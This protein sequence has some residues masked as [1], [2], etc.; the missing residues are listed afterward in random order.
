LWQIGKRGKTKQTSKQQKQQQQALENRAHGP[1]I[2]AEGLGI[3]RGAD[4][5]T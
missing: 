1:V 5:K 2:L 4:L 3:L